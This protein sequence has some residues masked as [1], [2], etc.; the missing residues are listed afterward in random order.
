MHQI[1]SA[2]VEGFWGSHD[3]QFD[4]DRHVT[5]FI[6]QNGTGKTTL[7]NLIAAALTADFRTLDRM[8]FMKLTINLTATKGN[9]RPSITIQKS[10]KK[11]RPIELM[12]Y[13]INLGTP[14][15]KELRFSL[16]DNEEQMIVRRMQNELRYLDYYRRF[17]SGVGAELKK[18][19]S[20][21]W[22]SIHRG[23]SDKTSEGR[24]FDS[25]VDQKI[26]AQANELVR[27]FATFSKLKDDEIRVFQES[28]FTG[29]L[30]QSKPGDP[31]DFGRLEKVDDYK[32]ALTTI[33]KELHV[34]SDMS[35]LLHSFVEQAN[36]VQRRTKKSKSD[37]MTMDDFLFLKSLKRIEDVVKRWEEL[38]VR[39]NVIFAQQNSFQN[40]ADQLFRKK[41]MKITPSNELQFISDNGKILTS[42]M[43]SSG[44]KQL[45]ILMTEA[46]LQR[47]EPAILIADEPELSLHVLWQE[48]LVGS[49]RALNPNAQLIVATHS[50][51]IVGALGDR[52][53][54][55]ESLIK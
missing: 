51:D 22:L 36:Q 17:Q 39:L 28:F 10:R 18:L 24:Q 44:E 35:G 27:Y 54:D 14:E 12:D 3:F 38:Q 15:S 26:E 40:I 11:G 31:I 30:E 21:N 46:L 25:T 8:P 29:L 49:L 55:M 34:V 4:L 13:R 20:V 50:P 33:F 37:P 5:F 2:S 16:D 1:V 23:T 6:G 45:L 41:R 48:R 19:V 52:A 53:I 32:T 43:L 42:Q 9:E 7:I 47:Q